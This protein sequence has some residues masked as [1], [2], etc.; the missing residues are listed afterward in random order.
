[1]RKIYVIL[2]EYCMKLT[3][4]SALNY[5]KHV[6]K[7]YNF[8]I[9]SGIGKW[10]LVATSADSY[11]HHTSF[12]LELLSEIFNEG[13]IKIISLSN[14]RPIIIYFHSSQCRLMPYLHQ[15][16]IF[17]KA[18]SLYTHYCRHIRTDSRC[19]MLD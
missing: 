2:V 13:G 5:Y 4:L 7:A 3:L 9:N 16:R 12:P 19:A 15:R 14:I 18:I 6:E 8:R 11:L 1:M 10:S 17:F